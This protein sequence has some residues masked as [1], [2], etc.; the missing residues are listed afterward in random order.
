MTD[1]PPDP[2]LERVTTAFR[3]AGARF[4]VIGG[5]AVVANGYVRATEDV[6][7]LVPDDAA[8]DPQALAALRELDARVLTTGAPPVEADVTREH[9]RVV[10]SG[11]LVDLL[12]E[13]VAPLD[14]ATVERDALSADLGA[15]RSPSRASAASSRSSAWPGARMTGRTSP[16]SRSG[17]APSLWGRESRRPPRISVHFTP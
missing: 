1:P 13:G 15:G 12:R 14:F 8:N 16:P 11:G 10:T 17:T 4:V 5:F 3:R 7:L 6:D 9:L 2:D